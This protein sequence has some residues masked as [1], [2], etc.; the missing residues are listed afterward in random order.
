MGK[1]NGSKFKFTETFNNPD[2]KT[3]GSSF[4]GVHLGLISMLGILIGIFGWYIG[5]ENVLDFLDKML[6]VGFLASVL[7][8][9]RKV[10]NVFEKKYDNKED[11]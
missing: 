5:K 8:G 6:Q 10:G 9:V 7:L 4:I 1:Y 2:G 11:V 3:S